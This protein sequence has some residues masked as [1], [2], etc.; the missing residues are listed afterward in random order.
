MPA[1]VASLVIAGNRDPP[2][3]G[4]EGGLSLNSYMN[5]RLLSKGLNRDYTEVFLNLLVTIS[6]AGKRSAM[7][8]R[9]PMAG[10]CGTVDGYSVK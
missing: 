1:Q 6:S 9:G 10:N 8:R 7:R 5:R 4:G 2:L 3:F